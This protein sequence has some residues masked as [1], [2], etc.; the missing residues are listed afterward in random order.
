MEKIKNKLLWLVS[1]NLGRVGLGAILAIV[2]GVLS[3]YGTIE[4][5][6]TDYEFFTYMA[7][8]GMSIIGAYVVIMIVYAWVINPI[9]RLINKRKGK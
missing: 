1:T 8:A 9:R 3:P 7:T 6:S 5:L 4:F 2:G